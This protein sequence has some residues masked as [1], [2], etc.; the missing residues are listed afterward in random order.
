MDK[1]FF[2]TPDIGLQPTA[3][4]A[5]H[6]LDVDVNEND[7]KQGMRRLKTGAQLGVWTTM[8]FVH[9]PHTGRTQPVRHFPSQ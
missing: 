9:R 4:L 5:A 3:A 2:L 7:D 6:Q 1:F 8:H